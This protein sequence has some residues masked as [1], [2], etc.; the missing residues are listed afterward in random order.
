LR[1][2]LGISTTTSNSS[3]SFLH[4]I[5]ARLLLTWTPRP[6]LV[7]VSRTMAP[8]REVSQPPNARRDRDHPRGPGRVAHWLPVLLVV[9]LLAGAVAAHRFEVGPRHLPWLVA[10]PVSE[11]Q[12]VPPPAGLD[13]PDWD[14]PTPA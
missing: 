11:P 10:D 4:V 8:M 6:C 5:G 2:P 13:L 3:T 12:A 7:A 14:A 1:S 9:A